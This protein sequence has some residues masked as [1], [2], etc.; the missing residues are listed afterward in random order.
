MTWTANGGTANHHI[1]F[2]ISDSQGYAL[3]HGGAF[4]FHGQH[5]VVHANAPIIGHHHA[6][7]SGTIDVDGQVDPFSGTV[8]WL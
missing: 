2:V 7:V 5:C 1:D 4:T 3:E 8:S 6:D